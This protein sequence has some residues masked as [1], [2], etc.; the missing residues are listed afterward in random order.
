MLCEKQKPLTFFTHTNTNT[1]HTHTKI[2]RTL[3]LQTN[4]Y[5]ISDKNVIENHHH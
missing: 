4:R 5:N 1:K 2:K 3:N